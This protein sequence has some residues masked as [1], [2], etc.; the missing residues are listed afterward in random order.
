MKKQSLVLLVTLVSLM[1]FGSFAEAKI[2]TLFHPTDPTLPKVAQWIRETD[3]SIDI[4]MY[5]METGASS[6][7]I[8][9]LMDPSVQTRLKDGSL[10]VR[11]IFEGYGTP[12]ENLEKM[13]SLEK[14]GV[15]VR[16][17]SSGKHVHH[18]FAVFDGDS[19]TRSRVIMGSANWSLTSFRNYDENM[20]FLSDE[21]ETTAQYGQEFEMLWTH[22]NEVG[23]AQN[24]PKRTFAY[25]GPFKKDELDAY[26]NAPRLILKDKN[27]DHVITDQ[28]VRLM[29]SAQNEIDIATTRVRL[30]PV[31]EAMKRAADRGVK[32][33]ILISQDDFHDLDKRAQWLFGNPNLELR[34][35]FYSLRPSDYLAFQMHNKWMIVDH[36]TVWSGSFNWSESSENSFIENALEMNGSRAAEVLPTYEAKF[37]E[38]WERGRTKLPAFQAEL[39]EKRE[40][41]QTPTCGFSP[42]SLTYQEVKGLIAL[43]PRCK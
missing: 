1:A 40:Q 17:L 4:A 9:A 12:A 20:I 3:R 35:K 21:Q 29:D 10:S 15:D 41:K 19:K 24:H 38:L 31:L 36:K 25:S 5:N 14:I 28:I 6:P 11:V 23:T 22:S 8:E 30:Q 7:V 34:I 2:E 33:K 16:E 32:I 27:P 18:K 39:K 42:I 37:N 26:F 43:A 13:T